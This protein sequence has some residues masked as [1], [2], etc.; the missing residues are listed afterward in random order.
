MDEKKMFN[1][2]G[3]SLTDVEAKIINDESKKRGYISFSATVRMIIREWYEFTGRKIEELIK[4]LEEG[5]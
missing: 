3:I 2:T 5:K 1:P 4:E